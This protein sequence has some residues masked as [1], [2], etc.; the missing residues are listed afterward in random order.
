MNPLQLRETTMAPATRRLLQLTVDAA[1]DTDRLY[2]HAAR[3][4]ARRRAARLARVQGQPRRGAGVKPGELDFEGIERRPLRVF[5]EKAYLDYSMYVILD[6]ALPQLADG[7]KPVQRRIIY[8]M[9]ELGLV[10]RLQA[11]EERAHGRRRDRQVPSARRLGLLRGHGAH[12]AGLLVPLS[13][14]RRPGQLGLDRRPEVVR[15]HAL[16]R[17]EAAPVRGDAAGR[18]RPGH[19]SSGCRTSTAR[20]RSRR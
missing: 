19:Q 10:G 17:G 2:R 4:E 5:T 20:S 8:A 18:A 12:G 11:Q 9:S 13:D 14:R 3:Q 15:G 6:R 16:H 1:D 7:L